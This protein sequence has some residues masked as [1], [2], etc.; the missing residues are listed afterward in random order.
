MRIFTIGKENEMIPYSEHDF[1]TEN[2]ESDLEDLLEKNP[3]YFFEESNI[4]IIGRQI[5]TNLNTYIDLLGIDKNGNAIIIELKRDKT[6]RET[7]AQ[8]IEYASFVEN[9]NYEQLNSI[10]Q[11]YYGNET[12]LDKYHIEYFKGDQNVSFNKSQKLLII[13]QSIS[14]EI[15]QTSIY[16]RK[17]GIDIHCM[18][19][20]YFKTKSGEKIISSDFIV[21][22][23]EFTKSEIKS[24]S[25]PKINEKEFIEQLDQNGKTFYI[26]LFNFSKEN[27]LHLIWGS[28]G[29]SINYNLKGEYVAILFGYANNSVYKQSIYTGFENISKKCENAD[30][31][32]DNYK[33]ELIKIKR[34]SKAGDNMKWQIN[35]KPD[36]KETQQYFDILKNVINLIKEENQET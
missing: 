29:F 7:L 20:K 35:S 11:T 24:K 13:G 17:N 31:I 22:D 25:L 3:Q 9:L 23:E 8:I 1:K 6:P 26:E 19:F 36:E 15:K 5:A 21:G 16:L 4:L 12:S 27:N 28:K 10:Y 32:I 14:K 18:E 2:I 30:K 34:F 33:M